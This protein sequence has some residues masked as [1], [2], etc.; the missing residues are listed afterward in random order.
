[1]KDLLDKIPPYLK[2]FYLIIGVLFVI[3]VLAFDQ[4]DIITHFKLGSKLDKLNEQ[5]E[6]YLKKIKKVEKEREE[7][8]NNDQ[9]LEK[10]AREKY[11]M[12]KDNED[13]Y[14]IERDTV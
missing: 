13:L 12:K 10:F 3:W 2:N 7:L 11:L 9:L 14:V 1:M 5:K 8:K 6:F 4:N